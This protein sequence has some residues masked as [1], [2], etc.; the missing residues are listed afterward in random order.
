MN[1]P[2]DLFHYV[3][4]VFNCQDNLVSCDKL[5]EKLDY[6]TKELKLSVVNRVEHNFSP[7]GA[8]IVYVLS[9]SHL[10]VHTWPEKNYAHIDLFVCQEIRL[11]EIEKAF[12][13]QFN[14]ELSITEI[15]YT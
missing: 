3:I 4:E 8:T 2:T 10:A 13:E 11:N 14:G 5:E 7:H 6:L 9:T 1:R 12:N 15:E